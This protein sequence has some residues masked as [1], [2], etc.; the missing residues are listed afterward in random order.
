MQKTKRKIDNMIN[1]GSTKERP[2]LVMDEDL[3]S[4]SG[5]TLDEMKAGGEKAVIS[6]RKSLPRLI[7]HFTQV[8]GQKA[9]DMVDI[10]GE[11]L[12][13]FFFTQP[14]MWYEIDNDQDGRS[15]RMQAGDG[16]SDDV[17]KLG[18]VRED[19]SNMTESLV[20]G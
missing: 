2:L 18:N 8:S 3:D 15:L 10:L 9:L 20:E 19:S 13:E 14:K 5:S 16:S 6:K 17:I 1:Y 11:W 4:R 7:F 12:A